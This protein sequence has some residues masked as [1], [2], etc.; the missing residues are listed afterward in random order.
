MRSRQPRS[1]AG[2]ASF[3]LPDQARSRRQVYA[4]TREALDKSEMKRTQD[5]PGPCALAR[6]AIRDLQRPT[7]NRQLLLLAVVLANVRD[8]VQPNPYKS[9]IRQAFDGWYRAA[10]WVQI[11]PQPAYVIAA[12]PTLSGSTNL[13]ANRPNVPPP[14]WANVNQYC[15]PESIEASVYQCAAIWEMADRVQHPPPIRLEEPRRIAGRTSFR[16][17]ELL[18]GQRLRIERNFN[19]GNTNGWVVADQFVALRVSGVWSQSASNAWPQAFYRVRT[20]GP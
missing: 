5:Q 3:S 11:N 1:A 18:R 7:L 13:P 2:R 4:V 9:H 10:R 12:D 19:L 17:T 8:H 15:E 14:D 16:M 20:V 6:A